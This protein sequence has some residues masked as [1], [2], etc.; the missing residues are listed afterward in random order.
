MSE[1]SLEGVQC[2][3]PLF[4]TY[5]ELPFVYSSSLHKKWVG[6]FS[7]FSYVK[8]G[9]FLLTEGA[10]KNI[11][12]LL[13]YFFSFIFIF[14]GFFDS[15]FFSFFL[16][17]AMD[18]GPKDI[19]EVSSTLE[20]SGVLEPEEEIDALEPEEEVDVLEHEEEIASSSE[21]SEGEAASFSETLA[22]SN[23]KKEEKTAS[24]STNEGASGA[25]LENNNFNDGFQM[26]VGQAPRER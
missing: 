8:S 16:V 25:S 23:D 7:G 2:S 11:C 5:E 13:M 1:N 17:E 3:P 26:P 21:I 9:F 14:C 20:S 6:G 12:L 4:H 15:H 22:E 24:S 18:P 10:L 19:T